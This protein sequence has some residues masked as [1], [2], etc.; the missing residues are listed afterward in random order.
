MKYTF[1][2]TLITTLITLIIFS[3]LLNLG[4]WQLNRA[5][6]KKLLKMQ[7]FERSQTVITASTLNTKQENLRFFKIQLT[8]RF[9]NEHP[10]FLANKTKSGFEIF[11]P[12]NIFGSTKMILVDRGTVPTDDPKNIAPIFGEQTIKGILDN[13]S[14]LLDTRKIDKKL[15]HDFY[16][17]V[18]ISHTPTTLPMNVKS[19]RH[20]VY[21]FQWFAVSLVLLLFFIIASIKKNS[22]VLGKSDK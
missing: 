14:P 21:A 19:E 9:D 11:T 18:V 17:Y 12:F 15:K 20:I 10:V 8:G 7:Y 4:F 16:P 22:S 5:E 2:P 6:F 3:A 13:V 1:R